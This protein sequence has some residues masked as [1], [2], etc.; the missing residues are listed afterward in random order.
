MAAARRGAGAMPGRS[1]PEYDRPQPLPP[2]ARIPLE[3]KPVGMYLFL[4]LGHI[5]RDSSAPFIQGE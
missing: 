2:E 3:T 1:W 4:E 5:A